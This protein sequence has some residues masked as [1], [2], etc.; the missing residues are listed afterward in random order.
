[1][2]IEFIKGT[3]KSDKARFILAKQEVPQAVITRLM[4]KLDGKSGAA[5]DRIFYQGLEK[6]EDFLTAMEAASIT[7]AIAV[8]QMEK[9]KPVKEV[10]AG[11]RKTKGVLLA[12][13]VSKLIARRFKGQPEEMVKDFLDA[14]SKP[15]FTGAVIAQLTSFK[16]EFGSNALGFIKV[17]GRQSNPAAIAA[18]RARRGQ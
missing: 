5:L 14:V 7:P 11:T 15:E 3:G 1:M 9:L 16:A 18:L 13:S 4:D 10:K 17:S 12:A 8:E 6:Y 2:K